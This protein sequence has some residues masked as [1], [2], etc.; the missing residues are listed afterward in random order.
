MDKEKINHFFSKF[1]KIRK[2]KEL[3]IKEIIDKTKIQEKYIKAIEKGEFNILPKVYT[4][5]FLKSYSEALG[6]NK[7]ETIIEY[8]N[9]ISGKIKSINEDK[10]PKFIENKSNLNTNQDTFK[11]LTNNKYLFDTKKIVAIIMLVIFIISS[12]ILLSS[13]SKSKLREHQ[14]Q[15]NNNKL[16]WEFLNSLEIIETQELTINNIKNKNIFNYSSLNNNKI[17]ITKSDNNLDILNKV[18]NSNDE[19]ENTIKGEIKFGIF[20]GDLDF[21]INGQKVDFEYKNMRITGN[22]LPNKKN[23]QLILNYHK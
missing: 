9:H 14:T 4:R 11:G 1:E 5:L 13:L 12:W 19:G 21:Y 6:I 8:E 3:S 7:E 18:L 2:E 10:T 17:I 23:K 22:F 15:F 20:S 16:S